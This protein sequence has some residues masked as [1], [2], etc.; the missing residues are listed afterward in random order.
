[1]KSLWLVAAVISQ[2]ATSADIEPASRKRVDLIE[3][4]HFIDDEGREVFQQLIFYDWSEQHRRFHVRAWRLIK[5]PSQRPR[6]RWNPSRIE[7]CWNDGGRIRQV[8]APSLRETWTQYDPE[9]LNR[10]LLPEDRR[11]PLFETKR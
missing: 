9:R 2:A 4:N 1:M 8:V 6:R 11:I 10:R 3:W 5:S 7:C